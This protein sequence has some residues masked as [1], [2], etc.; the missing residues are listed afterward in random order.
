M[1]STGEQAA[2]EILAG[3]AERFEA[4]TDLTVGIEEEYQLLDPQSLA[5]VNRFEELRDA[6]PDPLAARLAGEL[7]SSEI[8]VKTGRNANFA[9]AARELVE[10]R[11]ALLEV[12]DAL[13]IGI[14]ISGVH[15]F[16][17]WQEQQIIDTPHYA[18][19]EG[20]LG[21]I[22]WI[23]NTWSIHLHVG[24]A[25][26]DRAVAI[27]TALRSVLPEL[28]ALS[29]NSP[30]YLGRDTRLHSARTQIFT[31]S[32]PRCGIPDAYT[33]WSEYAQFVELLARTGGIVESTQIWWSVRPHHSYGTVEIR[34]CDGQAEV[35]EALAVAALGLACVAA[36]CRD[37]DEG[38]PVPAHPRAVI[39]ENLW[40]AQRHG[41]EG[42]LIRL[43]TA[44]VRPTTR[45]VEELLAWSADLHAPL[46]IEP[47]LA[48]IE[49]MLSQG[50]GAQRQR[51]LF[52]ERGDPT[53]LVA[54]SVARTRHSAEEALEA[55]APVP[56]P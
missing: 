29:A 40:R 41:L 5:L 52:E 18:R 14:G 46:G 3:V 22:A 51:A 42:E 34:I 20:E 38:I 47:F 45:A 11:L 12:A 32:F 36:F 37:H 25:G 16:S 27:S 44:D 49:R 2:A 39:E 13:G 48:P 15:P 7:I 21:Y 26:A 6:A 55:M 35:S 28:L 17:P 24:V 8:E 23:N 1:S 43:G 30:V 54:E 53:A 4:S 10:G 50:N 31:R 19:V 9:G 56:A 33:D